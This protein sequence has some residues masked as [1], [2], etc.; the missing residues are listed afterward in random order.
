MNW[1][2]SRSSKSFRSSR[3]VAIVAAIF[4]VM[5]IFSGGTVLFGPSAAQEWA[6]NYVQFIVW[7]NFLA[8]FAYVMAAIGLWLRT[9]WAIQLAVVIAAATVLAAAGFAFLVLNDVAFEMRTV[10]ALAF[11]FM[12]WAAVAVFAHRALSAK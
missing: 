11:R 10:G 9:M 7:F 5:T 3:P 4:G 1:L 2:R 8:G 6:G 12:F